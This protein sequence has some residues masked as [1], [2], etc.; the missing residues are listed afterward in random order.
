MYHHLERAFHLGVAPV[1]MGRSIVR[2]NVNSRAGTT[3][4]PV[5]SWVTRCG[6]VIVAR[7]YS[8]KGVGCMLARLASCRVEGGLAVDGMGHRML[9]P[10][11][12]FTLVKTFR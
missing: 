5:V 12:V 9:T 11:L 6:E 7:H 4:R 2:Y 8:R 3:D 10:H 1:P